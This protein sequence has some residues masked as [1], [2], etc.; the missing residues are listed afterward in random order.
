[1]SLPPYLGD[2]ARLL[3][4][5]GTALVA[6]GLVLVAVGLLLP[7]LV[8]GEG[9]VEGGAVIVIAPL[10]IVVASSPS[11]ARTL[12]LLGI[13]LTVLA[14]LLFLAPMLLARR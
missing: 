8:K 7:W 4:R 12:M 6:V 9:R 3:T 14:A 1:M 11:M 13:V 2:E 5:L 10:P